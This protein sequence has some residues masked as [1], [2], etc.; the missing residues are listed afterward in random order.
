MLT[1][2]SLPGESRSDGN[3]QRSPT[4][5]SLRI[6]IDVRGLE[7]ESS[8][9]RGIGRYLVNLI[10]TMA[11]LFG[12]R[13]LLYGDWP[14]WDVRHLAPLLKHQ[15]VSYATYS[16]SFTDDVDVFLLTDP[17]PVL[18][19]RKLVPFPLNGT[20]CATIFYDLIPLAFREK[21]LDKNPKLAAE[22]LARLEE[23]KSTVSHFLTISEFV[24]ADLRERLNIESHRLIPILGG[25]DA[26]FQEPP[27]DSDVRR[28]LKQYEIR[29]R[30][31]FYT[32]GADFR[33]NLAGLLIAFQAVR[34]QEHGDLELVLAGEI[35]ESWLK[36]LDCESDLP[37]TK[38]VKPLGYVADD[39][40]KCLYAG[41]TGFVFPS[42]Y[43]GFGLPA[44]EAMACGCPVIV[45]NGS[46]LREIVGDAGLLVNPDSLEDIAAGINRLVSDSVLRSDLRNRGRRRAA[47]YTWGDVA[48][49]TET[50]LRSIARKRMQPKAP[51][52]RM[53]VLIQNR[54][55]AFIAPG[56]D[57]MVMEELFRA[58]RSLDVD[59]DVAAGAPDL[60]NV[61]LVH[62]VNLTVRS[63]AEQ[64][65]EN[66][67]RQNVPYVITTLFEDWPRYLEPSMNALRLFNDYVDKGQDEQ[68]FRREL[69]RLRSLPPGM[70]V[71]CWDV[72]DNAAVLF[73]C[74]ASEAIR[75][76]EAYPAVEER[77]HVAHFGIR[78]YPDIN[79]RNIGVARDKIGH[80]RF[81]LCC[82]RLETRKNQLMLLKAMQD[83]ELP[84]VFLSGGFTYQEPYAD[85]VM[86]F[87]MRTRPI[88]LGRQGKPFLWN[89]MAAAAVHVLPSWYELPGLVT[90][91]AAAAGT[92]VAVSDWGAIRDYLPGNLL[93]ICQPDDPE[94]IRNAVE[95]ALIAGPNPEAK[96]LAESF[97]WDA[98]GRTTHA[99]YEAILSRRGRSAHSVFVSEQQTE[100]YSTSEVTMQS[101][102][103]AKHR[104]D[105][106]VIIPVYN[107][108]QLTRECLEALSAMQD[109]CSFEVIVI[110][111]H[112]TDDTPQLLQ[113]V[114]GDITVLRQPENR[115][116][117]AACNVGARVASGEYL[118][119]LN[120]DTRPLSGWLDELVACARTDQL[121]GAVGAKLLFP[122]GDVQHAGVAFNDRGIPYH[123][124]Q[125]FASD[126]PAVN[127]MRDMKAVTAA[128]VL[129]PAAVFEE[130]DGFDE[131]YRNGFE[132]VD[133]CLRLVEGGL[134]VVYDP[135]S[136]VIH[137]EETSDGR[138]DFDREN[139][140][141][142]V[143]T[144]SGR[145]K[146]DEAG[147]L[148]RHGYA[149]VWE[150][151]IGKY[152]MIEPVL[153]EKMR[154]DVAAEPSPSLDEA[155]ELYAS[156]KLE[157]AAAMLQSVVEN[158]LVLAGDDAF[159]A[160]QTLGNCLANLKRAEEAEHAYHA[161]LKLNPNSER[162]YL[163]LGTVAMLKENWQAAMYGFMMALAKN[164]DTMKG[165]FGV[166]LSL[167]ARNM[168]DEAI[169]HFSR[170][171]ERE[172]QN[173]EALFYLYRSAM[174]SGQPRIAV[175]PIETY[176]QSF[177][178]DINFLFCLCG[179]CWK[180]GELTR[181]ADLCWQVLER[182]PNHQAALDVMDHLKKTTLVHA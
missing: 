11:E 71:G 60:R 57:T 163:G 31:L 15:N 13:L 122:D 165:E 90:L 105:A 36:K 99:V 131:G 141:R 41:A 111:N 53:R 86:R 87:P 118:V 158:R 59:V 129:V 95:S 161:A 92:A 121:I 34:A 166:G 128:C 33:K 52:R 54:D 171:L 137:R 79:E 182:D 94:S 17:A 168:H 77:V 8:L 50:A 64:V 179:A 108:A 98:F 176:L 62:L 115:G 156:G 104:F 9:R 28:V 37:V 3:A 151:G 103:P 148:T 155:R 96:A 173:A 172:P 78:P 123:I 170:I 23:L 10:G 38:N 117:A 43:E 81:I 142:F 56:G 39:D 149:L 63:V 7:V 169:E 135:R 44:L 67:R 113:A 174:E 110:D 133:F 20:P 58:L 177:P 145:I 130:F 127:E 65:A 167:A 21:Y 100:K 91:E 4:G 74:G 125:H 147:Y 164:P 178:Q 66:A 70:E 143:K 126:H 138:K 51:V 46:S 45:S 75:L 40:L 124:F 80:D 24:A 146:S 102:A 107:H 119:F 61:D 88:I 12:H 69:S 134:R 68:S 152:H 180:A 47:Q 22:Y 1:P 159:E 29:G 18:V 160:W 153:A 35:S 72:A 2:S 116:F 89:L 162:P 132:D 139:L 76:C 19:G 82:G 27:D 84:I 112:S 109:R 49:R 114:E 5:R 144:W 140:D 85:L 32:G 181:A 175:K 150:N 154:Q 136:V 83:S 73:A 55:N 101:S 25:L 97:T 6:G 93:H 106:S 26:A 157:E 48:C 42:L 30:Y 120:N 14:P 16:P